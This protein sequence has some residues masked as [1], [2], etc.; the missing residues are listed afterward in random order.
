M[1]RSID[2][3]KRMVGSTLDN[4]PKSGGWQWAVV[5]LLSQIAFILLDIRE[6]VRHNE[7]EAQTN[8]RNQTG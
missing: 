6:S 7:Q 3:W 1:R 4:A 5:T 8:D 2:E